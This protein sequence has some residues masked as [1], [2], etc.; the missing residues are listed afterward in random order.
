LKPK[1]KAEAPPSKDIIK[2]NEPIVQKAE[3]KKPS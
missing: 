1:S 2:K 3:V